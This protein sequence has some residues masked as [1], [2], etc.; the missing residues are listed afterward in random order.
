MDLLGPLV[1]VRAVTPLKP[2]EARVEFS[3]ATRRVIDLEMYLRGPVFE[4][5]RND[6]AVFCSM[7]VEGGTIAW[8]NGADVDPDVLYH[9]LKP[10]WME[11]ELVR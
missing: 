6:P 8:S 11:Q 1:R 10:A 4:P 5:I 2:Y 7:K 9:N 3:D